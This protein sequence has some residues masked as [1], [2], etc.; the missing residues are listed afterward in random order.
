MRFYV[1]LTN[2]A[3]T[4]SLYDTTHQTS[5]W[6]TKRGGRESLEVQFHRDKVAELLPGGTAILFGCK[7]YQ[8]FDGSYLT[9]AAAFT[10]PGDV[11]GFYTA[12][13]PTNTDPINTALG[14][15]DGTTEDDVPSIAQTTSEIQW[16][17]AGPT[18]PPTKS[19][20]FSVRIDNTPNNGDE[21]DPEATTPYPAPAAVPRFLSAITQRTGG[22]GASLDAVATAALPV[23]IL[24]SFV[25]VATGKLVF[26]E[27]ASGAAAGGDANQV[28]PLDYDAT[29]NAKH[30]AL[31]ATSAGEASLGN[32]T[33][34]N[35]LLSSLINGT[36]SWRATS[37][38]GRTLLGVADAAAGRTA[39]GLGSLATVTPT[40]TANN[41]TVL[42]GDG[43]YRAP[44]GGDTSG[45]TAQLAPTAV[46]TAAYAAAANDYVVV[47]ASAGSVVVTLPTAPANGTRIGVKLI[48]VSGSYTAT[49]ALGGSDVL[50]KSGGSTSAALSVLNQGV[51]YQYKSGIWYGTGSDTPLSALDARFLKPAGDGSAL[52]AGTARD[53]SAFNNGGNNI[54]CWGDSLTFGSGGTPYPTQLSALLGTRHIDN[55][56][57]AGATSAY[58]LASEFQAHP[59]RT[60]GLNIIWAGYNDIGSQTNATILANIASMVALIP[61]P[62]NFAVLSVINS[63]GANSGSA[64]YTQI[65]ALNASLASAYG[66]RY[67]DVRSYL[68]S[69]YNPSLSGD[70]TA[71]GVDGIPPSLLAGDGIHLN[72]AGYL[73]VAT[74]LANN[75]SAW[76]AGQ[77]L[78]TNAGVG[79]IL[80]TGPQ[81]GNQS[82]PALGYF[83]GMA[84]G[85]DTAYAVLPTLYA[86]TAPLQV[87]KPNTTTGTAMKVSSP[88]YGT[89]D[90]TLVEFTSEAGL[91]VGATYRNAAFGAITKSG[92]GGDLVFYTAP[93]ATSAYADRLHIQR[94]GGVVFSGAD[95]S[96]N[97]LLATGNAKLTSPSGTYASTLTLESTGWSGGDTEGCGIHFVGT[98]SGSVNGVLAAMRYYGNQGWAWAANADL[99][100][101]GTLSA[102]GAQLMLT[103]TGLA[104]TVPIKPASYTISTLPTASSYTGYLATVTNPTSGKSN[105]VY[106]N[107]TNWLYMDGSTAA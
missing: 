7:P 4:L 12:T 38:L 66:S 106:S 29:T 19:L 31:V 82:R 20:T 11:S 27:L 32:P 62:Q 77:A 68:V 80:A 47:D 21:T 94:D 99:P 85:D 52:T 54:A 60:R 86:P 9:S 50:N 93:T 95:S 1:N 5:G 102:S 103:P 88:V 10:A 28:A 90:T 45:L 67:L 37:T 46:K 78:V 53:V 84:V 33:S 70:V 107:G 58:I 42:Y 96:G 61:A 73:A 16:W 13:L 51:I 30:F 69:Q 24:L 92:G 97:T 105:V 89:N 56:G 87:I 40:G 25:E 55:F 91:D 18:N 100:T 22:T 75:A 34:D 41:T 26:F 3:V 76:G 57:F 39:L 15:P 35:S 72:T 71:H 101:T 83:D 23:G 2:G 48:A 14:S 74:F 98:R 49:V 79:S 44:A 104:S 43:V 63:G 64:N 65:V 36:R 17:L 59:E 6:I 81:V 8:Q